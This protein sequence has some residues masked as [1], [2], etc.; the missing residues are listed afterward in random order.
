M[1]TLM[2]VY[3][4]ILHLIIEF[5]DFNKL[6]I[7]LPVKKLFQYLLKITK[8]RT[9]KAIHQSLI[10]EWGVNIKRNHF[11]TV[12]QELDLEV[13]LCYIKNNDVQKTMYL[14]RIFKSKD[15]TSL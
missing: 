5:I 2:D 1:P 9:N 3:Q 14:F 12:A 7:L 15:T 4:P 13:R 6:L 11:Q 8:Q 10:K